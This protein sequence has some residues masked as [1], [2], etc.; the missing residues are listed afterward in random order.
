ML[1]ARRRCVGVRGAA[2]VDVEP[3][4]GGVG[5]DHCWEVGSEAWV[6]RWDGAGDEAVGGEERAAV[7]LDGEDVAP[8]YTGGVRE[9]HVDAGTADA[10]GDAGLREDAGLFREEPQDRGPDRA[11]GRVAFVEHRDTTDDVLGKVLA[12]TSREEQVGA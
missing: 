8:R 12:G 4:A 5:D 7:L 10:V 2:A 11:C 3:V 1:A 9:D 6:L